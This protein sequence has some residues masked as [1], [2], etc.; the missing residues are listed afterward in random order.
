MNNISPKLI[1][2]I[3][4]L[5]GVLVIGV[6]FYDSYYK[7]NNPYIKNGKGIVLLLTVI[8]FTYKKLSKKTELNENTKS[9]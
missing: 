6:V 9:I 1:R 3:K 2:Y 8:Y 4:I 5:I 7:L